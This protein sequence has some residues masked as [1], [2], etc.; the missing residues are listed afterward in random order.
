MSIPA[1]FVAPDRKIFCNF[2]LE[3]SLS[4]YVSDTYYTIEKA[5]ESVFVEKRSRFLSYAY[6]VENPEQVKELVSALEKK[7]YDAR[8]VCWAYVIGPDGDVFRA[9]DNGE[10][11]GTAGRPILGQIN[12]RGLTN[13][14]VAVVRYFGGI[15]LG[16]PGLI[17]AYK[18]AASDVL[19]LA[20]RIECHV[21]VRLRVT[22]GYVVMNDV[23]KVARM[24]GVVVVAN[25][26]DNVCFMDLSVQ[27]GQLDEV[28]G[29]LAKIEG[30]S[31][32]NL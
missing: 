7:Y 25:E 12:S 18:Q 20:G 31:V 14:L 19:D 5:A 32:E 2:A 9:N 6:P 26:F 8:H 17:K 4:T 1:H 3:T 23:M 11:S 22:F 28:A 30:V 16:T 15:K 21:T 27:A 29:R 10:P 13:V 24:P